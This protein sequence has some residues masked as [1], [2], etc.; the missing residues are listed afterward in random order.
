MAGCV[1]VNHLSEMQRDML[2]I[3]TGMSAFTVDKKS[4]R[5]ISNVVTIHKW[6]DASRTVKSFEVAI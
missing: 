1:K 4:I 6:H 2:H 5:L 3:P